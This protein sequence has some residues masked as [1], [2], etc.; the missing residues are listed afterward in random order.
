MTRAHAR[1][2][3]LLAFAFGFAAWMQV[4]VS[5]RAAAARLGVEVAGLEGKL[6]R[7]S[8]DS[9][10][11][12]DDPPMRIAWAVG[13]TVEWPLVG[14]WS[15]GTGLRYVRI[16][17]DEDLTLTVTGGGSTTVMRGN[18]RMD[19]HWIALPLRASFRAVGPLVIEAGP[20]ARYLVHARMR[21]RQDASITTTPDP[22]RS[23]HPAP[24][25]AIFEEVG[26]LGGDRDLTGLYERFDL[27]ITAGA[28]LNR[29]LA[30]HVVS[31]RGRYAHGLLDLAKGSMERSARAFELGLGWSW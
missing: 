17:E 23:F 14:R 26:T 22:I 11:L 1:R 8:G 10:D 24:A 18:V 20:E 4:P 16:N 15:L 12:L 28:G 6:T 27:A 31:L 2:V 5:A 19:W 7:G 29:P 3:V 21:S 30:G 13:P 9:P 25:A